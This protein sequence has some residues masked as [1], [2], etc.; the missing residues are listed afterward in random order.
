LV[1]NATHRLEMSPVHAK[2]V[3]KAPLK[4]HGLRHLAA[5]ALGLP[6][7]SLIFLCAADADQASSKGA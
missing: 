7:M 2:P 5:E 1:L 6:V 4:S 3:R